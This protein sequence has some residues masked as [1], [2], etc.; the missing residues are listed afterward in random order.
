MPDLPGSLIRV[1]GEDALGQIETGGVPDLIL[2]DLKMPVMDGLEFAHRFHTVYDR[3]APIILLTAYESAGQRAAEL[4]AAD[5]VGKPF[6]VKTLIG[7]VESQVA[8]C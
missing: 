6:D 2:L 4:D 5:W 1:D 7:K 3:G 8:P